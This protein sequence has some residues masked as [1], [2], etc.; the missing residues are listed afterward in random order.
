MKQDT[1][2]RLC[3][4]CC[5]VEV[6]VE[7]GRL[8]SA[9][10]KSFLAPEKHLI[11]PKL[12]AAADIVYSPQRLKTPLIKAGGVFKTA[13]WDEALAMV[14]D[15]FHECKNRAGARS[16]CWLRGM[17]ADWGAPWDY[18]NRLMNAF[19]SPNSIGNGSV[20][21]V[22][23]EFAHTVTYGGMTLP[24]VRDARCILVWG[25]NDR[26][27][28]PAAAEGILH[29]K[30]NGAR[31]IV[32][33]P[34]KT[35]LA[36]AADIWLQIKPGHDGLLAMAMIHEIISRKLYDAAF[37]NDWTVGFEPLR[38]SAKQFP[39]ER[40]AADIWLD[41]EMIRKAAFVYATV[42]PA[43][44]V[45]G[46]GLDMQLDTFDATRAVCMLRAL[47]G[48]LDIRGGDFI[49]QPVKVR[50]L[51]LKERL[52]EGLKPVTA[53]YPLFNAFHETWGNHVQSCVVDAILDET[54]Y[55]LETLVV[56]SGNPVVTMMDADRVMRALKKLD[57]LVAIDMF[58]TKT[59]EMADVVLPACSCFEKTQLNRAFI[60]NSPV[61]LQN[62]V[63]EPLADS[64]PDWWIVF[65]LARRLGLKKE[66]PWQTAEAAIDYQLEPA[67]ITVDMLRKNPE[68]I[69]AEAAVFEKH[70]R[71]GFKTRS[72]KV[73]F[74]SDLLESN[75]FVPVPYA[76]GWSEAPVGFSD[77]KDLYPVLGI[78]GARANRFTHSQFRRIPV[79][80]MNEQGCVIDIHPSD[81][82]AYHISTGDR[83]RVE[84]PRGWIMMDA[85][86]SEVVHPGAIRIAWG[87]GEL[88]PD[89]NLNRLTDD[90]R[91]NPIIGTP[92][93]RSF[94]CRIVKVA[95]P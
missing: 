7:N 48:N 43:C 40:I 69:Q 81:A 86:I 28:N 75:G 70:K 53:D 61:R 66:F 1:I 77:Q 67:G 63:I 3:S 33:D 92:A 15:R 94:M 45:D 85:R 32:V 80:S 21:H 16:I 47:S 44:I 4:S 6:T 64:R 68:G 20:C 82:G 14:A 91:R 89:Y 12:K 54:P 27:T 46:N 72:G 18:V 49:P 8:V 79:L 56:Q 83:I 5:P 60:R 73:A 39:A 50:N 59:A 95:G 93:G 30:Q 19:G 78:S 57:F 10:R 35:C 90:E 13:S 88:N 51:Q 26:D 38:Q 84:T 17:A 58:M 76:D 2:C 87:W 37:V 9:A 23:R 62:R 31:L 71:N 24:L 25:K 29:A 74:F 52:P 55:P 42:K 65:E 34:V 22:G 41:P 11:C 36:A